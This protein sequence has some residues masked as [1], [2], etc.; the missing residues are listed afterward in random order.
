M[1]D[2]RVEENCVFVKFSFVM[3]HKNKVSRGGKEFVDYSKNGYYQRKLI[4]ELNDLIRERGITPRLFEEKVV[5]CVRH[6]YPI[7]YKPLKGEPKEILDC[8]NFEIKPLIDIFVGRFFLDDNGSRLS[9]FQ[10]KL[11]DNSE[12][13]YTEVAIWKREAFFEQK[14]NIYFDNCD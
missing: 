11:R 1:P 5:F 6:H 9:I 13:P 8:D 10:E 3:P 14:G 7:D 2:I 4:I 12:F